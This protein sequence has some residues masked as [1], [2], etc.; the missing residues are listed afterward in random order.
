M[1]FSGVLL[2]VGIHHL[3][4]TGTC[5][6]TGY[7]ANY[8]PVPT[9][10]SGTGWWMAFL[11]AGIFGAIIGGFVSAFSTVGLIMPVTF[12]GVGF[13]ALSLLFDSHAK[14]GS[15]TFGAIFGGAFALVAVGIAFAVIGG[16]ISSARSKPKKRRSGST[17][18]GGTPPSTT[19]AFGSPQSTATDAAAAS[20]FGG[21]AKSADPILGAYAAGQ[22]GTVVPA[23][24]TS[25]AGLGSVASAPSGDA[26]DKI[27]RLAE[28]H[29]KGVLT[30]DEFGREKAKIL[31]LS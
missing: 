1:L 3:I 6:S 27:S 11:F 13:G 7:S 26:L 12:G 14:S 10:P 29:S 9:C 31:G 18:I 21:D 4:A 28:L 24:S 25:V 8:G 2:G 17:I 19:S 23:A 30:D 20:V 16:A 5:S 15:K 22:S